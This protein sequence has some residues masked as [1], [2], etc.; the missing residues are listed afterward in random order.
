M[1]SPIRKL[2]I[3]VESQF[4]LFF[5]PEPCSHDVLRRGHGDSRYSRLLRWVNEENSLASA[6]LVAGSIW[7]FCSTNAKRSRSRSLCDPGLCL[8]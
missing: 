4:Y 3:Q 6:A 7:N 2:A 1:D 5:C 8:G